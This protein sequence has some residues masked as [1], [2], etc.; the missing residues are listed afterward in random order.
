MRSPWMSITGTLSH[1]GGASS[2]KTVGEE[3]IFQE[4][5]QPA[6]YLVSFQSYIRHHFPTLCADSIMETSRLVFS[7]SAFNVHP[8]YW[9]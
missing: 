5:I 1:A 8:I 4:S 9:G 7:V 3:G 2:D 6:I